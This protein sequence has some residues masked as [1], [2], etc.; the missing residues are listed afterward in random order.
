MDVNE[1]LSGYTPNFGQSSSGTHLT[2]KDGLSQN[3]V[4]AIL[5]DRQGFMW[6]GT[7][8]GLNRYDRQRERFT[9]FDLGHNYVTS[10]QEDIGGILWVGTRGGGLSKLEPE[11]NQLVRFR[12]EANNPATLTA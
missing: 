7:A 1:R 12:H 3:A 11:S 8:D 5:Q 6:F 2:V 4:Y 10:I 9:R